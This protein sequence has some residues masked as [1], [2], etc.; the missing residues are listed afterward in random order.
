MLSLLFVVIPA[1]EALPLESPS[2]R[3]SQGA[4]LSV[5]LEQQASLRLG[6]S[7]KL[8]PLILAGSDDDSAGLYAY[9]SV[10]THAFPKNVRATRLA[11]ACGKLNFRCHG[12]ALLFRSNVGRGNTD[13][14]IDEIYGAA[15]ISCDLRP[16]IQ[17]ALKREQDIVNVPE[18]L[19]NAAQQNY[20]DA[21]TLSRLA[22]VMCKSGNCTRNKRDEYSDDESESS[23]DDGK[24]EEEQ[25]IIEKTDKE[26]VCDGAVAL[27]ARNTAKHFVAGTSLCLHCRGPSAF[28]C[29]D[30]DG[31]YFCKEPRHCRQ[32]GWSHEC[33]SSTW[34]LYTERRTELS[35]FPFDEWH[36][37]LLDRDCQN[38]EGRIKDF[39]SNAWDLTWIM[40]LGGEPRL[41][42]G[43]EGTVAVLETLIL[44][45]AV[46]MKRGLRPLIIFLPTDEFILIIWR[47][48]TPYQ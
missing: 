21:A 30:C 46:H 25:R 48:W 20:H 4:N 34:K 31:V 40:P 16:Q 1:D 18:W 7:I 5:L 43:Q 15:C 13:L 28:L 19:V 27:S 44:R 22:S 10:P 8:A 36:L 6:D 2:L 32:S 39:L 9:S 3:F 41:M 33:L 38:S 26:S 17:A 14:T 35:M 24:E 23:S 12:D 42:V 47:G 37:Q 29:P 11:M 45:Y